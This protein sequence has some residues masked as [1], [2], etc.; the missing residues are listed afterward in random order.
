MADLI[1]VWPGIVEHDDRN[2]VRRSIASIRHPSMGGRKV[3]PEGCALPNDSFTRK[4][5]KEG[6][7]SRAQVDYGSLLPTEPASLPEVVAEPVVAASPAVEAPVP[8]L[9]KRRG[10]SPH[11]ASE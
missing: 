6:G 7:L 11:E 1:Q 10:S 9:A 3:P 4:R 2:G 5:I 8:A